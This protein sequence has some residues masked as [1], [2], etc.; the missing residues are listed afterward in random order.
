[1]TATATQRT[2]AKR[3]KQTAAMTLIRS[4]SR[5]LRALRRCRLS[6]RKMPGWPAS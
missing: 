6:A 5:P 1:M 4:D 2:S 3:L